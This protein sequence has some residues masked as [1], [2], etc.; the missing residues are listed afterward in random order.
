MHLPEVPHTNALPSKPRLSTEEAEQVLVSLTGDYLRPW[1]RFE[2][3]PH[4]L[5]SRAAA[6]P[7]PTISA[8]VAM[9]PDSIE[10]SNLQLAAINIRRGTRSQQVPCVVD[11]TTKEV[12]LFSEG[13]WLRADQWLEQAPLP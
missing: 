10:D 3:A 5:Y 11:R 7:I 2:S 12:C 9:S 13:K 8:E 1:R 4:R 6:R